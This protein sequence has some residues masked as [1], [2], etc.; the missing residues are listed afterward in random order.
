MS[1]KTDNLFKR[2]ASAALLTFVGLTG[3]QA[4]AAPPYWVTPNTEVVLQ[5]GFYGCTFH[6]DAPVE[7]LNNSLIYVT[8]PTYVLEDGLTVANGRIRVTAD[9][10]NLLIDATP[11]V[12]SRNQAW[13]QVVVNEGA[14]SVGGVE[15]DS[16]VYVEYELAPAGM[17]V[18]SPKS[19]PATGLNHQVGTINEITLS[20]SGMYVGY[21]DS[22]S[23][24]NAVQNKIKI[25]ECDANEID[26]TKGTPINVTLRPEGQMSSGATRWYRQLVVTPAE[27]LSNPKVKYVLVVPGA[28]LG[29]KNGNDETLDDYNE[30]IEL[31][32]SVA[33][34]GEMIVYPAQYQSVPYAD[35]KGL[36]ITNAGDITLNGDDI[37]LY[38]GFLDSSSFGS[39][40]DKPLATGEVSVDG[41]NILVSFNADLYSGPYTIL[42][43]GTPLAGLPPFVLDG[44]SGHYGI[45]FS[46]EGNNIPVGNIKV[47]QNP[48]A[49][50]PVDQIS[51]VQVWW[52]NYLSLS[53]V[54]GIGGPGLLSEVVGSPINGTMT[55]DGGEPQ[56]ITWLI[57][58]KLIGSAFD[59]DTGEE[60]G[61]DYDYY[62]EYTPESPIT[63]SG[64][65]TFNVPAGVVSIYYN[66][67]NQPLN[68]AVSVPLTVEGKD[69]PEVPDEPAVPELVSIVP[70]PDTETTP[71][72]YS[73]KMDLNEDGSAIVTITFSEALTDLTATVIG[74]A[75]TV[76]PSGE[77]K[78][79]TVTASEELVAGSVDTYG[80][81]NININAMYGDDK[82]VVFNENDE[83]FGTTLYLS[84]EVDLQQEEEVTGVDIT[85][86]I[87][88]GS[89]L[90]AP[91]ESLTVNGPLGSRLSPNNVYV[92][93]LEMNP[94]ES[95]T[96][97]KE[98][99]KITG[100]EVPEDGWQGGSVA[101]E[102]PLTELGEYVLVV[103][104]GA[105][106]VEVDGKTYL[107]NSMNINFTVEEEAEPGIK[108]PELVANPANNSVLDWFNGVAMR[109]GTSRLT[110]VNNKGFKVTHN[111]VDITKDPRFDFVMQTIEYD[112]DDQT[113]WEDVQLQIEATYIY[114]MDEEG[115]YIFTVDP[116]A[117]TINV[118]GKQV[119]NPQVELTYYIGNK[120]PAAQLPDPTVNPANNSKL[121]KL[122][123]ATLRWNGYYVYQRGDGEG[124]KLY[125]ITYTVNGGSPKVIDAEYQGTE[126]VAFEG[127]YPTLALPINATESGKYVITIPAGALYIAN[128][129][130]GSLEID[131]DIVLTYDV[132]LTDT[133]PAVLMTGAS[134]D[135][136]NGSVLDNMGNVMIAWTQYTLDI[137]P[138]EGKDYVDLP[139]DGVHIYINGVENTTWM[140]IMGASLRAINTKGSNEG[141]GGPA[142][143]F[144][145]AEILLSPGDGAFYWSGTVNI[146]LPEGLVKTT[147]GAIS[148]AFDLTYYLGG[149][150]VVSP[151]IFTPE[152]GA[153]FLP[154]EAVVYAEWNGYRVTAVNGGVTANLLDEEGEV[155]ESISISKGELSIEDGKLR[156]NLNSLPAGSYQMWV[157]QGTV[158]LGEDAINADAP[159]AF[160]IA[161]PEPEGPEAT[162]IVPN[163]NMADG[164]ITVSWN[165][166]DIELT[167][168]F[169]LTIVNNDNGE[170]VNIEDGA[171]SVDENGNLV[172]SLEELELE[173]GNYTLTLAE[174]SVNIDEDGEITYNRE[175]VYD[176]KTSGVNGIVSGSTE[177]IY[178]NLDGQRVRNPQKG[179]YIINGQKVLIK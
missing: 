51:A 86:S 17:Q 56:K 25:Y 34:E 111:G 89:T 30:P 150:D 100:M 79:W 62:L 134:I 152:E 157:Q 84:Y 71:N 163:V 113:S 128:D 20:W 31:V 141:G 83:Y 6:F 164:K 175:L 42:V 78:V 67:Q 5:D 53:N 57:T 85:L 159:Y 101:F 15:L 130:K 107:S 172:I 29:F 144:D 149:M 54:G 93:D 123:K 3:Y 69:S 88:E 148:P 154:G 109:W 110:M 76:T 99:E 167:D 11:E 66:Q 75:A 179:I 4:Q 33:G 155:S 45:W 60:D 177:A 143:D 135:P 162:D 9:G 44:V 90:P 40:P 129:D 173:D 136:R 165:G 115:T 59:E 103:P 87:T 122:D 16:Q 170:E 171:V 114:Q 92:A 50:Q 14:I 178:F 70:A 77:G 118:D 96:V 26:F 95:I 18:P 176:F 80:T 132:T 47:S 37:K 174:G 108:L 126:S 68:E 104:F 145:V 36:Q 142:T 133:P 120:G 73:G 38:S 147:T 24:W 140:N 116:G 156:I 151:A 160:T 97:F 46:I 139:L 52:G 158:T 91:V 112:P 65:Y 106:N 72:V 168:E 2:L 35:W 153:K 169:S 117:V 161:M 63:K 61:V 58:R 7:I 125:D 39:L 127:Y 12:T 105:F 22:S 10:N 82:Y 94:F 41:N 1:K 166:N 81:L 138:A 146:V 131:E 23:S 55:V 8:D 49:N 43:D 124:G 28:T 121:D 32:Y 137:N 48:A 98:L 13:I 119:P 74:E 64:N 19:T 21:S 27:T 102:T